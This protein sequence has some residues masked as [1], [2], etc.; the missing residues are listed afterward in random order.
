M[1][2]GVA[3]AALA[4]AIGTG[5]SSAGAIPHSRVAGAAPFQA[6]LQE[7]VTI[8]DLADSWVRQQRAIADSEAHRSGHH[9][10]AR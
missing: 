4:L 10:R 5:A 6:T 2:T 3:V 9:R 1:V 7:H 8:A